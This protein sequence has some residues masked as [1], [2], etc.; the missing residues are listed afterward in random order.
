MTICVGV[1]V[2]DCI[3]FVADSASSMVAQGPNG[4]VISRVYNHGDKLFNLYRGLPVAAMTCG[5]GSFGRESIATIAKGIRVDL[6]AE[7]SPVKPENYTIEKIANFAHDR[8][9]EKFDSLEDSVKEA[10]SFEFFVGGYSAGASDSEVWKFQFAAGQVGS[11]TCIAA[12]EAPALLWAGQP[13][14]V[15]A[16]RLADDRA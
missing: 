16:R 13:E 10:A 12:L 3:V 8:F 11:P 9:Q 4:P 2:N 6:M 14:A 15:V 7:S 5:L 1:K